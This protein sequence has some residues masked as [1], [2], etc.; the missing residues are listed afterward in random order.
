M[1]TF[2]RYTLLQVPSWLLLALLLIGLHHW[3][4]LSPWVAIGLLALW[5]VKDFLLYPFVRSAYE[6]SAQSASKQLIGTQGIARE[7]LAPHGYV[8]VRGELWRAIAEPPDRPILPGT[9]I[10]V[11]DADGLTLIVSADSPPAA[12]SPA[13]EPPS[14]R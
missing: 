6:P 14:A 1:T 4:A 11:R 9:P 7:R 5:V 3:I 8:Q 12:R 13:Q 2:T 10:R